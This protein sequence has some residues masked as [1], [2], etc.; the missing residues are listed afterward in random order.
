[1]KK[2]NLIACVLLSVVTAANAF[3]AQGYKTGMTVSQVETVLRATSFSLMDV[4]ENMY[5]TA[6]MAA[7]GKT[8]KFNGG[9][10]FFFC[11]QG[12]S[13]F[14]QT[15]PLND[16]AVTLEGAISRYGTPAKVDSGKKQYASAE[17][18]SNVRNIWYPSRTERFIVSLTL[19]HQNA[20]RS[21][22]S[23]IYGTKTRCDTG[24]W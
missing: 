15:S 3:D 2:K 14:S 11:D 1:M 4:G 16:Y 10:A 19:N 21:T 20:Q 17:T 6:T 9:G 22:S 8:L 24:E 18:L 7:D 12:L 13:G 5:A 23:V